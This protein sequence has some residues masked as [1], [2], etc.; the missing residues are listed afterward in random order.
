MFGVD[1]RHWLRVTKIAVVIVLGL[2]VFLALIQF[3][4]RTPADWKALIEKSASL[5]DHDSFCMGLPRPSDFELKYKMVGGNS[6]T[7]AISYRFSSTLRS[8][9]VQDFYLRQLTQDG[10]TGTDAVFT[11]DHYKLSIESDDAVSQPK[12]YSVYCAREIP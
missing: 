10:W 12:L 1:E 9:E 3:T 11:R 7:V 5:K 6:R 8:T 4:C 2:A